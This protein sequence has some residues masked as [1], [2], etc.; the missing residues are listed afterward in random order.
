MKIPDKSEYIQP[1]VMGGASLMNVVGNM[2]AISVGA[3]RTEQGINPFFYISM[4]TSILYVA[5]NA[6]KVGQIYQAR[7]FVEREK[8]RCLELV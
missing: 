7:S 1:F 3:D 4:A 2:W 8:D 6:V 5:A